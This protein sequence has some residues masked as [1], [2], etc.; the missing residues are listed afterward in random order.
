[1]SRVLVL[2]GFLFG[3]VLQ[4]P[5]SV[6][7]E[8]HPVPEYPATLNWEME[9]LLRS[10]HRRIIPPKG[11]PKREVEAV[12]GEGMPERDGME[13]YAL[14][15]AGQRPVKND[16]VHLK[17]IVPLRVVYRNERVR[18]ARIGYDSARENAKRF[19]GRY[20]N[21]TILSELLT[22]HD[23]FCARLNKATWNTT[24]HPAQ[25]EN[26]SSDE[27]R[28]FRPISGRANTRHNDDPRGDGCHRRVRVI[29]E[30]EGR[31]GAVG[32]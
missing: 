15:P 8:T 7:E 26:V 14:F 30:R 32:W 11:T 9:N 24:A 22:F 13:E 23:A 4:A 5:A 27:K 19:A 16:E 6:A 31:D 10:L 20:D 21:Y 17:H 12:F 1:M 2:L 29:V 28:C 3:V 25:P 18:L